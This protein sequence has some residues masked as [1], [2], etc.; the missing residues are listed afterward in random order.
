M[1]EFS[2]GEA[3]LGTS[4]DTTGLDKDL[5]KAEQQTKGW[6]S[7]LEG[8]FATSAGFLVG[9]LLQRGL[10]AVT[11]GVMALS[12]GMVGGNAQFEQYSTQFEVLL[13]STEAAQTRMEE[14]AD[15]GASTPFDLPG[16][17]E[18]DR[19]L[20]GFGLHS[21]ST[22]QQ[23]GF[24]GE[25]IRRIAGDV[26]S[27]TGS[28]FQ[29]MALL[30]GR[31][32]AGATGEALQR[33]AELGIGTRAQ[34]QELGLEFSKSGEL[35]SPLPEAMNV[36][37]QLM[38]TKYGG[39]ME[40]QSST[41]DGM[42][43]NLR[44]WIDGMLREVGQPIFEKLREGLASLLNLLNSPQVSQA[45]SGVSSL[46]GELLSLAGQL[47]SGVDIGGTVMG[48]VGNVSSAVQG[49]ISFVRQLK[50]EL[51][52]LTGMDILG[53][54]R[55]DIGAIRN[56]MRDGLADLAAT[57]EQT[58]A[59]ING[60]IQSTSAAMGNALAS[61]ADKY[62]DQAG[63]LT[64]KLDEARKTYEKGILDAESNLG[65]K[66]FEMQ[67]RWG[68]RRLGLEKG[69]ADE[70][71]SYHERLGE[72]QDRINE[73]LE[74]KFGDRQAFLE[75]ALAGA[76]NDQDRDFIKKQLGELSEAELKER[77][78]LEK[79]AERERAKLKK[80]HDER[81]GA[82]QERL[83]QE[84][85]EYTK[86]VEKEKQ[87]HT[88]SLAALKERLDKEEKA[89]AEQQG[90]IAAARA[91]E[92]AAI[93][94]QYGTQISQLQANL[95]TAEESYAASREELV[96]QAEEDIARLEEEAQA[97]TEALG[98][99][100]AA[101][102]A[103]FIDGLNNSPILTTI[104]N[105]ITLQDV[106]IGLGVVLAVI[107]I[108]LLW[109]LL[110][111]ILP[112]VAAVLL[113]IGAV[114]L[115]RTAWEKDFLGIRTTLTE[116]WNQEIGPALEKIR[117]WA[118]EKLP[119]VLEKLRVIWD[120]KLS[121]ALEK[122]G[123]LIE[124]KVI[125]LLVDLGFNADNLD[126]FL[127]LLGQ[128]IDVAIWLFDGW[129]TRTSN[130]VD[131]IIALVDWV[132]SLDEKLSGLDDALPDWLRPG[133]PTPL[134]I[135]IQGIEKATADWRRALPSLSEELKLNGQL[136]MAV[137]GRGSRE[138]ERHDHYNLTVN[139]NAEREQVADSYERMKTMRARTT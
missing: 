65:T 18:A 74:D 57:H 71:G 138:V 5:K 2:L 9:G 105:F 86:S 75:E 67:E 132:E 28:S 22:A 93:S 34:L 40:A 52:G 77:A 20:Q 59:G 129:A 123:K 81:L 17:V 54:V 80:Q 41:F 27:G 42:M 116:A 84:E 91:K 48:I 131:A 38:D 82:L 35:L 46:L 53:S 8:V 128:T 98:E 135:G 130:T 33:M 26:A 47:T 139:S 70:I 4:A 58:I 111:P 15:F 30:I 134:E 107:I 100:P 90:R 3:T 109:G 136:A 56:D 78:K 21:A 112:I 127:W 50:D 51:A 101:T 29:E 120:E 12:G 103:N 64:K 68:E 36:L 96:R 24:S 76:T 14:L 137:D 7:R 106:L 72:I 83:A 6:L 13:G 133:S 73:Q 49:A 117:E 55:G 19:I 124:D 114:A 95:A 118:E 16:V 88:D 37:L 1:A 61:I 62:A 121:P 108:P 87:R 125:P 10:A 126:G 79:K 66:L 85:V 110:A 44:D 113:V 25:E 89:I 97:R 94:A 92:E 45:I 11:A 60:S 122:W 23:F 69:I 63:E 119:P 43:S 104:G 32:S 39:L 99:G 31:F 102:V 115:L